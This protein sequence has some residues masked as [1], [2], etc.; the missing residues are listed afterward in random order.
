MQISYFWPI[1]PKIGQKWIFHK[2]WTSS[3]FTIYSPLIHATNQKKLMSQFGEKL[4]KGT[5]GQKITPVSMTYF[6]VNFMEK[7]LWRFGQISRSYK[8]TKF[9][10]Q[11]KWRHTR[12]CTKYFTAGFPCTFLLILW[13]KSMLWSFM[14]FL[15]IFQELMKLR[16]FEWLNRVST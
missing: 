6:L 13:R 2:N 7:V 14:V 4:L 1:L 16:S 3:L 9:W 12:E 10:I 15:T 11:R 8:F 5:W